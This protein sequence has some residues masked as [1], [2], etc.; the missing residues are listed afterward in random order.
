MLGMCIERFHNHLSI[1]LA[2]KGLLTPGCGRDGD[3]SQS[4]LRLPPILYPTNLE[5]R[6]LASLTVDVAFPGPHSLPSCMG[7]RA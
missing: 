2:S 5:V 1:S 4:V 7:L 3:L 6:Q